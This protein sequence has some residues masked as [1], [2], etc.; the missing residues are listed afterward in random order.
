M[1]IDAQMNSKNYCWP[2]GDG[3][4]RLTLVVDLN[5]SYCQILH[6][7]EILVRFGWSDMFF[8]TPLKFI[9]FFFFFLIYNSLFSI[10]Q[11]K[12]KYAMI[13]MS[14][15]QNLN[16]YGICFPSKKKKKKI[17][18]LYMFIRSFQSPWYKI[19]CITHSVTQ[20]CR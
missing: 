10:V 6:Q 5:I 2:D 17:W 20:S 11:T 19:L 12:S 4:A 16:R 1:A 9:L 18:A 13:H 8:F 3:S 15:Q 14:Y 7:F